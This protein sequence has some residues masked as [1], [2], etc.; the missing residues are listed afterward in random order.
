MLLIFKKDKIICY[1]LAAFDW[2]GFETLYAFIFK[3]CLVLFLLSAPC[4]ES[5]PV[6]MYGFIFHRLSPSSVLPRG[7]DTESRGF[8]KTP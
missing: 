6:N 3:D 5:K 4:L 7:T 8:S 1:K 2:C